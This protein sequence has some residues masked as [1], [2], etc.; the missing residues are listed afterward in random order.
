MTRIDEGEEDGPAWSLLVEGTG[1]EIVDDPLDWSG[2]GLL[3]TFRLTLRQFF[4]PQRTPI[5]QSRE[6]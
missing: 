1:R 4:M 5:S 3:Q 2:A 6:R